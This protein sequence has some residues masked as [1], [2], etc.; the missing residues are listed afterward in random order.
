MLD[1]P[2]PI[3]SSLIHITSRVHTVCKL[4][5]KHKKAK[6]ECKQTSDT[7]ISAR[8]LLRFIEVVISYIGNSTDSY[9]LLAAQ[10]LFNGPLARYWDHKLSFHG[11]RPAIEVC[12]APIILF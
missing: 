1:K 3:G 5:F 12:P 4:I 8:I 6:L 11:Y 2:L 10:D 9:F 7:L